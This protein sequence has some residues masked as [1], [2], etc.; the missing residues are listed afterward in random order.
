MPAAVLDA[1]V[2]F[3]GM[4]TD[5][6]LWVAAEGAFEPVWSDAIHD[7]WSRNLAQHL[8]AEKVAYRRGEMERAFP[9][10]LVSPGPAL[11]LQVEGL[12]RTKAQRK[13]AH[14]V[15]TAIAA[16][17]GTVATFNTRDFAPA[18]LR[19][20]G[21]VASTPDAFLVELLAAHQARVLAG[22]QTHRASLKRT[23][24]AV[25]DYLD[26]LA[27]AK[28]EVPGFSNALRPYVAQI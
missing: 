6:L 14:V 5:L 1:C 11:V 10:A 21:L 24:P 9:A 25:S 26:G 2:L 27:S 28:A 20:Y 7:E 4:L 17:A 13:D 23:R 18:V 12:C 8:G 19:R 3:R 16:E 22:V 15:A